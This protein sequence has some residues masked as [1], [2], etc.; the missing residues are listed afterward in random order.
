[1]DGGPENQMNERKKN[2]KGKIGAKSDR[3][4]LTVTPEHEKSR[5]ETFTDPSENL[6]ICFRASTFCRLS[7]FFLTID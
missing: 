7:A 2:R 4:T 5:I 3:S 1:M 6:G